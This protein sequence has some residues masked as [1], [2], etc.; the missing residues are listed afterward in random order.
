MNLWKK[1]IICIGLGVMTVSASEQELN[2]TQGL[3]I[4]EHYRVLQGIA[5]TIENRFEDIQTVSTPSITKV[6]I[7]STAF[8]ERR[9]VA[10]LHFNEVTTIEGNVFGDFWCDMKIFPQ[11]K[12]PSMSKIT[13]VDCGNADA[14]LD[15]E[16]SISFTR[17]FEF[18]QSDN[19]QRLN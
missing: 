5:K 6:P 11:R 1:I 3:S 13:L 9:I 19:R 8:V 15:K 17:L 16:I 18:Y 2:Q 7:D 10:K 14:R 4:I 12:L